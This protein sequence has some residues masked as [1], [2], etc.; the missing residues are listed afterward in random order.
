MPTD[1]ATVKTTAKYGWE[2]DQ[3]A[4]Y[5]CIWRFDCNL[6]KNSRLCYYLT[7]VYKTSAV[8]KD[9]DFSDQQLCK[10]ITGIENKR[11]KNFDYHKLNTKTSET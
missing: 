3:V 9:N 7:S 10:L 2:A 11:T 5:L 4:T 6:Q 1:Q 8:H